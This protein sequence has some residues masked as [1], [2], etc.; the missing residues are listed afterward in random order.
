MNQDR[1]L[2]TAILPNDFQGGRDS[3]SR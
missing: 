2:P 3:N 1:F